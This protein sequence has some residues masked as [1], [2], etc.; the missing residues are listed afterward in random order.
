MPKCDNSSVEGDGENTTSELIG[1]KQDKVARKV[2]ESDSNGMV[3]VNTGV[4]GPGKRG[5]SE[6]HSQGED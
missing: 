1:G 2:V 4:W 5:P 6:S 3:L